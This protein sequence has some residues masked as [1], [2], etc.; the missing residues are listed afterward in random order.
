MALR[1][2]KLVKLVVERAGAHV[3][4]QPPQPQQQQQQ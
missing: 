2:V 4:Q 1:L 3:Q